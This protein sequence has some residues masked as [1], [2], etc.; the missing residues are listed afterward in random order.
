MIPIKAQPNTEFNIML[1]D[2]SSSAVYNRRDKDA[3]K[4]RQTMGTP[5]YI[6]PEVL[7]G[8]YDEKCDIWSIGVIMYMLLY[9]KPPFTGD[10]EV[11][12]IQNVINGTYK[13]HIH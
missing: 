13:L 3:K 8:D 12:I 9:G 5:Y 11:E 4:M 2:F 6:A 10:N 1:T 7:L